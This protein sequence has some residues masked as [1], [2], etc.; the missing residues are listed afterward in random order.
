MSSTRS[1]VGRRLGLV[2]ARQRHPDDGAHAVEGRTQLVRRVAVEATQALEGRVDAL[3]HA[4]QRLRVTVHGVARATR[5]QPRAERARIDAREQR[6]RLAQRSEGVARGQEGDA[7]GREAREREDDQKAATDLGG[8]RREALERQRDLE[9][10]TGGQ[11][12][13]ILQESVPAEQ[14]EGVESPVRAVVLTR[15]DPRRTLGPCADAGDDGA[16]FRD[17]ANGTLAARKG[18][19]DGLGERVVWQA[20][21]DHARDRLAALVQP[22]VCLLEALLRAECIETEPLDGER[23]HQHPADGEDGPRI[24]PPQPLSQP[25][26]PAR[27]RCGS[28]PRGRRPR[29]CGAAGSRARRPRS[30]RGR[31]A[32]PRPRATGR[33]A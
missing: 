30:C 3:E 25:H 17:H 16:L 13:R 11:R 21:S 29:A 14:S 18:C 12:D 6:R 2:A 7:E 9:P 1:S 23:D 5:G 10:M 33:G 20:F 28:S 31:S 15:R 8:L 4:V 32:A 22:V 24:R 19:V 26:S 27:A